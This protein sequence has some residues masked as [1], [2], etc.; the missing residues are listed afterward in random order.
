QQAQYQYTQQAQRTN[1]I[2]RQAVQQNDLRSN[3]VQYNQNYN[4]VNK[5][6]K[7]PFMQERPKYSAA[8]GKVALGIAGLA[9]TLPLTI[10]LL[11]PAVTAGG[12]AAIGAAVVA[13]LGV[14]GSAGLTASGVN[15]RKLTNKFYRYAQLLG[16][17]EYFAIEDLSS[18]AGE[19]KEQVEKD[20]NKMIASNM[21]PQ[22]K[23][24]E[25]R[26][27]LIL[28]DNAYG[29]YR[30]AMEAKHARETEQQRREQAIENMVASG[31]IKEIMREGERVIRKIREYNDRIPDRVMS[32][33]LDHL[34]RVV[35]RI[36]NKVREEPE[37]AQEL[38]K[39]MSY[40][41]PTTE[42]LLDAYVELDN[43]PEIGENI[44]KTK[45]EINEALDVINDAF[46]A[47]LDS[48]FQDIAWDIS[49]DITVMKTMMAQDGLRNDKV[50]DAAREAAGETAGDDEAGKAS[51]KAA[52]AAKDA[53]DGAEPEVK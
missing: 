25:N 12:A 16:Q 32:D 21:L 28:T 1:T 22:A 5:P 43:Q 35:D 53:A 23:F 10:S 3:A 46:E 44:P 37:H 34:E 19:D 6:L 26:K 7:T 11:I 47:L 50:A 40:Y 31:D 24:D 51:G 4:V 15:Q 14:G 27:T 29:Q 52:K 33:K 9:L 13:A 20:L 30:Q 45:K 49:S 48:L 41:L 36:F 2:N 39:F 42:K 18:M 38:G 8:N 17:S